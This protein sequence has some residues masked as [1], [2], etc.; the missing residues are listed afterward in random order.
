MRLCLALAFMLAVVLARLPI[1]VAHGDSWAVFEVHSGT[2]AQAL[3]DGLD[4]D[5]SKLP[6]YVHVRGSAI[7]GA[8]MVPLYALF[9][10]SAV[11]MKLAP[12]LWHAVTVGLLVWVLDRFFSR[13]A[14]IAGGLLFLCAPPLMAK[15]SVIGFGSH[16]ESSL[17]MLLALIP[18]LAITLEKRSSKVLFFLFGLVVGLSHTWHVQALLQCL[19]LSALL[20]VQVPRRLLG[21]AGV[22]V[23]AGVALGSAPSHFFGGLGEQQST[24]QV[25][26]LYLNP[27]RGPPQVA[28]EGTSA[29]VPDQDSIPEKLSVLFGGGFVQMLEFFEAG[30]RWKP[31]LG[32]LYAVLLLAAAGVA[33]V[34]ERKGLGALFVRV[35][36]WRAAEVSPVALFPL[37]IVTVLGLHLMSPF[38]AIVLVDLGTGASNR[39]LSPLINS[40][41]ILAALGIAGGLRRPR[42]LWLAVLVPLCVAGAV[43]QCGAAQATEA[44][45]LESRGECYEWFN[46][47]LDHHARGDPQILIDTIGR[48]DRGDARFR[49]LRF[50]T[51]MTDFGVEGAYLIDRE[52]RLRGRKSAEFNVYRA[53]ALGRFLSS[54]APQ[55]NDP[56]T[57][58]PVNA[59]PEPLREAMLHGIGIGLRAPRPGIPGHWETALAS[60]S[61]LFETLDAAHVEGVAEGFGFNRGTT[62]DV[63]AAAHLDSIE[64]FATLPERARAA[65]FRG[66]G[67]GFRQRY[68][69]PPDHLP[70][71]LSVLERIPPAYREDFAD[72]YLV[73][74]VPGESAILVAAGGS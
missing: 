22:A 32:L 24:L 10:S 31:V 45:L 65:F 54:R 72:G 12:L 18:Y 15:L 58:T 38:T 52:T 13:R 23:L 5:V 50:R 49:S 9:G 46:V 39:R 21:W 63:Y 68:L 66:L 19:I 44:N 40:L 28:V 62:I 59:A 1:A 33:L 17:F 43:G 25:V 27:E 71:G 37:H 61:L 74:R 56:S 69:H 26:M 30:P 14:A 11:I 34:R 48:I 3:L 51:P 4:L 6:I 55:L 42:W 60:L 29:Y 7:Y 70:E 67:W 41:M 73:R 53:T 64:G 16:M 47:Q 20:V 2:I 57:W 35:F 36:R 8:L